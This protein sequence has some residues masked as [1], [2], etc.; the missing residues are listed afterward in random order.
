[1]SLFVVQDGSEPRLAILL[2][3]GHAR[4]RQFGDPGLET[5][6]QRRLGACDERC[7][8]RRLLGKY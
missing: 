5:L 4:P 6:R 2:V 1:M 3:D 7:G 8:E